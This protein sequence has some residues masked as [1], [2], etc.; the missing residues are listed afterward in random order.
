M[1]T[2]LTCLVEKDDDDFYLRN[3]ATGNR[4]R[5]CKSCNA[6]VARKRYGAD[7][8][9]Y[10]AGKVVRLEKVA[11]LSDGKKCCVSC[12]VDKELSDFY[13]RSK[14]KGILQSRCKECQNNSKYEYY[15][16]NKDKIKQRKND[17]RA[18]ATEF[19]RNIKLASGCSL[20]D[21]NEPI[22]LDFHHLD[23]AEKGDRISNMT[24]ERRTLKDIEAEI[25]KCILLCSN[26]HRKVHAGII[27][28]KHEGFEPSSKG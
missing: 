10:Q 8:L 23:P 11:K 2:C 22:A 20:C 9:A 16:D 21:E 4:F 27:K 3:K 5:R 12:L 18:I 17:R 28:L 24:K 26:C 7:E 1:I 14:A 25:K 15:L 6:K 13:F 19:V